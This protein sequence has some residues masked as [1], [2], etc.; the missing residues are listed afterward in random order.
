[1]KLCSKKMHVDPMLDYAFAIWSPYLV[2]H[3][4]KLENVQ[5]NGAL[6]ITSNYNKTS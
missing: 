1:M 4:D 5:C 3:I 2:K 6:F